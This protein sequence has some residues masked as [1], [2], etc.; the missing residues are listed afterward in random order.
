MNNDVQVNKVTS[1]SKLRPTGKAQ[2]PEGSKETVR[3]PC[4]GKGAFQHLARV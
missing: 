1:V 2:M 4:V 3:E